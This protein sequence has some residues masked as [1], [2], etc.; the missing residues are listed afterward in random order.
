MFAY[1]IAR[2]SEASTIRGI[3]MLFG[4]MGLSV[5]PEVS[6]GII[7]AT[8]ATAGVVGVAFADKADKPE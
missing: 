5:A 1:I 4:A 6:E 7:T 3:I 2:L 8:I